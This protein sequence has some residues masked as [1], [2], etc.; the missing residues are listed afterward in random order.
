MTIDQKKR[1]AEEEHKIRNNLAMAY[2]KCKMWS[3][4]AGE[5]EQVVRR[6]PADVKGMQVFTKQ[7]IKL[8]NCELNR[9][10]FDVSDQQPIIIF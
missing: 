6:W 2:L 4:A 7:F 1:S 5:C 9:V 8:I 10:D 3:A